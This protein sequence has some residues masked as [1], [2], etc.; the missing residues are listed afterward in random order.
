MQQHGIPLPANLQHGSPSEHSAVEA[1]LAENHIAEAV[2]AQ[3]STESA[4]AATV[5]GLS[6][7]SD[8]LKE[9]VHKLLIKD[10]SEARVK[11]IVLEK[12]KQN[13]SEV[14]T[15]NVTPHKRQ[16]S[17]QSRCAIFMV[18][19]TQY[20]TNSRLAEPAEREGQQSCIERMLD[21]A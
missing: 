9:A 21:L 10:D 7:A 15:T 12:L 11:A 1:A 14:Q 13:G 19:P 18:V 2:P 6:G 17:R 8:G 20:N 16:M 4:S 3:E 5:D